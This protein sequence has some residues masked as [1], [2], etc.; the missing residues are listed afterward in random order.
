[1]LACA[2]TEQLDG[3]KQCSGRITSNP[4]VIQLRLANA[5][6]EREPARVGPG[7]R[8]SWRQSQ[9]RSPIREGLPASPKPRRPR[10]PPAAR[11]PPTQ[12][13]ALDVRRKTL[14][15]SLDNQAGLRNT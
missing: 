6:F 4:E 3:A 7:I 11:S 2:L 14:K 12:A 9:T 5:R 8:R 13:P 15:F 1:M 10:P